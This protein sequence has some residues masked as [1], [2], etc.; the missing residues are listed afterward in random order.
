MS[1]F[2][3]KISID[4]VTDL[5]KETLDKHGIKGLILDIDNTLTH[6]D[7]QKIEKEVA[8]WL[9]NMKKDYS[10]ILLSN[11]SKER[12]SPFANKLG[13]EYIYDGAKPIPSKGLKRAT[14]R[15]NLIPR[16]VAMIGD[17]IFTDVLGGNLIGA[18]TIRVE[19]IQTEGN[20]FFKLKRWFENKVMNS[21]NKKTA[22]NKEIT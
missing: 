16:K 20:C 14:E 19:P 6:H 1:L 10:I 18:L 21:Y 5:Q 22:K 11:N 7:S 8:D 15:L 13:L 17:Q 12:V 9:E 3:P 4:K 2:Y